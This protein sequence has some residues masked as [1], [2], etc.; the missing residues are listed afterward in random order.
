MAEWSAGQYLKFADERTRAV[1][2]LAARVPLE[3]PQRIVDIGCG[4]G[5][6]TE[7]LAQLWPQ[8]ALAGFDTSPEM[9]AAARRRL[10]AVP[11][12]TADAAGWQP[13]AGT[14]LLFSNAVF[15]WVPDHAAVMT[16]LFRALKP[17]AVLAVQM[18]DNTAEMT[19]R[20][21]G[22]VAAGGPWASALS[23]VSVRPALP[24]PG[25]Y[26]DC[27]A[28]HAAGIDIWHTVYNHVMA[29]AAAIVEWVKG[30]SLLPFLEALPAEMR[31]PFLDAYRTRIAEA[32]AVRADGRRLLRF[33]RLF[34]VAVRG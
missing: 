32:Y 26:Y 29:D 6:S 14:D 19:H 16:R 34:M 9:L 1:R 31:A 2:E 13:E 3:A 17:G 30:T 12:F 27:L 24:E 15:Q 8:A 21:A 23:G 7:V 4:P 18:P 22:A 20:L 5:N 33:P 25:V 11:F 10:P 28:P